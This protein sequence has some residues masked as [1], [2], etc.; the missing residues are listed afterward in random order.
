MK[1]T[2]NLRPTFRAAAVGVLSAAVAASALAG[3]SN[4]S[5][6]PATPN[7][8]STAAEIPAAQKDDKL[9]AL[10][11]ERLRSASK[12]KVATSAPF[13]PY[14]M[15]AGPGSTELIGLEIDLGHA[16]GETLGV[17]FEFSQ[18]PYDGIIPGVQAGKYDVVM[19]TL[20]DTPER[21]EQLDFVNYARSGSG[22]M[23][24]Q[25]GSEIKT[26]DDLCGRAAGVQNGSTQAD[27]LEEQSKKC[28]AAA[29][30]PIDIKAFPSQ[31]DQQLAL[32][33]GS[34]IAIVGDLPALSY[35]AA[36]DKAFTVIEDP[37][38][39]GGYESNLIGV[40]VLKTDEGFAEAVA[41]AI[42]K[43]MDNGIYK[44]I[45]DKYSVSQTAIPEPI[46]NQHGG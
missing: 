17:P 22:I 16:I 18:Q 1:R 12:V 5:L 42:Q 39:Q 9:A 20:F 15:F 32:N 10:V 41:G 44:S 6:S 24:K 8:S 38:A 11:P 36:Q 26:L 23:I 34:I 31:S 37:A 27:L 29:K 35:S 43:L 25:T 3:C 45:L 33:S 30:S 19:A 13:A 14:E 46:V 2:T 40:G 21:E 4:P 28:A 7:S